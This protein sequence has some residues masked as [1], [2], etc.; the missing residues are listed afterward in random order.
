[1]RITVIFTGRAFDITQRSVLELNID[2]SIT[3]HELI[4]RICRELNN[5]KLCDEYT[6]NKFLF[7]PIVN[8]KPVYDYNYRLNDKD[9]VMFITPATGG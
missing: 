3:I 7:L 5:F 6:H 2:K 4:M 8:D 9:R 1:M